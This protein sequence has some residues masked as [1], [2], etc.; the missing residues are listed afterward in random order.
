MKSALNLISLVFSVLLLVGIACKQKQ[1]ANE[2]PIYTPPP[3]QTDTTSA[4]TP[5]EEM[6]ADR[7]LSFA[8]GPSREEIVL[9]TPT[10][11]IV[12]FDSL[13]IEQLKRRVGAEDFY[14]GADDFLYYQSLTYEM[15]DS[16]GIPVYATEKDTLDVTFGQQRK[17]LVKDETYALFTYFFYDGKELKRDGIDLPGS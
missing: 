7:R 12:S 16:L 13:E 8:N 9:E 14:T 4:T 6:E 17:Q 15:M 10:L 3:T 1:Q 11:I 2:Q 5:T